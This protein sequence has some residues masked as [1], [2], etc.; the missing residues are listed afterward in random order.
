MFNQM[1]DKAAFLIFIITLM[2]VVAY[3]KVIFKHDSKKINI[4]F[5]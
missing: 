4:I 1:I 3:E 5:W 2:I